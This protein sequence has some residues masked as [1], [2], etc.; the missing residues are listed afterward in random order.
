MASRQ[1]KIKLLEEAWKDLPTS[2]RNT[3][4][5]VYGGLDKLEDLELNKFYNL[6]VKD[7][8]KTYNLFVKENTVAK[9]EKTELGLA[10]D[11]AIAENLGL[12]VDDLT[13]EEEKVLTT[14]FEGEVANVEMKKKTIPTNE[15]PENVLKYV[16]NY[17]VQFIDSQTEMLDTPWS[18]VGQM[19]SERKMASKSDYLAG[20]FPEFKARD[21]DRMAVIANVS[22]ANLEDDLKDDILLLEQVLRKQNE[23]EKYGSTKTSRK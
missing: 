21:K 8:N 2:V 10:L 6:V 22:I 3:I 15:L 14:K 19:F 13:K 12:N 17:K 18:K 11:E 9:A 5:N 23:M 7:S 1:K 20:G 4:V 16:N